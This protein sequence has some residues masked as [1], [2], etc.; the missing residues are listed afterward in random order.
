VLFGLG[1]FWKRAT[2]PAAFWSFLFGVIV[3]FARLAADI[4]MK[5]Y[6]PLVAGLKQQLYHH[7]ITADQY[8]AA[9]APLK[10][11]Y[12]L[13]FDIWHIHWLFFCQMLLLATAALMIVISL[14]TKA[15]DQAKLK[16]SWYGATAEEKAVTRASWN[17]TDVLYSV[18]VVAIVVAFYSYFW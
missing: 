5:D 17:W 16:Y 10:A 15:P 6:K 13:I 11:K 7:V 4:V 12:G 2:A 9:L 8:A 3:G 18:V 1:V 14:L